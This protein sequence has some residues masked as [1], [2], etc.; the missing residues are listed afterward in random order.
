MG[1]AAE[2]PAGA[3]GK[4]RLYPGA[5]VQ[6][7]TFA[8]VAGCLERRPGRIAQ[9]Q[10]HRQSIFKNDTNLMINSIRYIILWFDSI[11]ASY[12]RDNYG[13]T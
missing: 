9:I 8:D 1:A 10:R 5:L 4:L 3:A 7:G 2:R 12:Q 6:S 11:C 13:F